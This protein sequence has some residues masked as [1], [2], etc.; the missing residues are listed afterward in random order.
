M[1]FETINTVTTWTKDGKTKVIFND[2]YFITEGWVT[3]L[4]G[5]KRLY[6]L[7]K[8]SKIAVT[9]YAINEDFGT[10]EEPK[11][12]TKENTIVKSVEFELVGVLAEMAF[13]AA[14]AA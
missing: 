1:N 8:G 14:F 7:L 9:F 3:K 12:C 4:T 6:N 11:I 2:K 5:M 10:T 13:K